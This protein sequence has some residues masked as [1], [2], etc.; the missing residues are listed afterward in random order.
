MAQTR[1]FF[2]GQDSRLSY[3]EFESGCVKLGLAVEPGVARRVFDAIDSNR[4]GYILFAEF[5]TWAAQHAVL[6]P[7][8]LRTATS[9]GVEEQEQD[10]DP[11]GGADSAA[12]TASGGGGQWNRYMMTLGAA[13]VAPSSD[14]SQLAGTA[15]AGGGGGD[16]GGGDGGCAEGVEGGGQIHQAGGGGGGGGG[17]AGVATMTQQREGTTRGKDE[18]I[19]RR[20]YRMPS[21]GQKE[22]KRAQ[23]RRTAAAAAGSEVKSS[24]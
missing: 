3:D 9:W 13:T 24:S 22:V 19:W 10:S 16:S 12:G 8:G 7:D 21:Q 5:C 11:G 14:D 18:S 2:R 1:R 17:G 6:G 23:E 15:A 4:G 20:D